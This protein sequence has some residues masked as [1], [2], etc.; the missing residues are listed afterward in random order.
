MKC[1]TAEIRLLSGK[2]YSAVQ[3]LKAYSTLK[4]R[5]VTVST[6]RKAG[7]HAAR[8]SKVSRKR[9]RIFATIITTRMISNA[10]LATSLFLPI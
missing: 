1:H 5:I 6:V 2:R 10:L 7:L 9:V 8:P 3:I 4:K